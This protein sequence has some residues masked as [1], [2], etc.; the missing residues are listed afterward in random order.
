[1]TTYDSDETTIAQSH[2]FVYDFLSDF[3]NFEKLMPSQISQWQSDSESCSFNIQNMATLAMR[4]QLREPHHHLKIVSEGKSPFP[5]D[6][7]CFIQ[8]YGSGWCKVKLQFNAQMNPMIKMMA[9]R[10]L[11]NFVNLLAV[12]LKEVCEGMVA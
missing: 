7:Q 2:S 3:N 6:L 9:A 1:M 12:K 10:P 8:E 11:E 4:Y 5:F